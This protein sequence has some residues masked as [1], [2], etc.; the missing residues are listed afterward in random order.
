MESC[1]IWIRVK[2][3]E[4]EI[5][6]LEQYFDGRVQFEQWDDKEIDPPWLD[7]VNGIFSSLEI[8]DSQIN[9][10]P[11]LKWIHC[12]RGGVYSF[13][14]PSIIERSIDVTSSK[15]IHGTP[16]SEVALALMLCLATKLP[17]CWEAQ[18]KRMWTMEIVAEE[19]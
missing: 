17:Q 2:L 12:T 4:K 14:T 6:L 5:T 7:K 18:R 15:G 1:L 11:N 19:F 3:P 16:F 9:R 10:M 13:L 8:A